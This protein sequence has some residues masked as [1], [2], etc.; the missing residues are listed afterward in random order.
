MGQNERS[1]DRAAVERFLAWLREEPDAVICRRVED[2]WTSNG[3]DQDGLIHKYVSL[4]EK[5]MAVSLFD[6]AKGL[7]GTG[8]VGILCS[9]VFSVLMF[10]TEAARPWW[11]VP[12]FYGAVGV[13]ATGA[14]LSVLQTTWDWTLAKGVDDALQA[15]IP[16]AV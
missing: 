8:L 4:G 7:L 16:I 10:F 1:V 13:V 5:S 3:V 12:V 11:S 2:C 9:A 14:R 15:G 6:V